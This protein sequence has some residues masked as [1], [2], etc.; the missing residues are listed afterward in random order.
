MIGHGKLDPAY[1]LGKDPDLVVSCRSYPFALGLTTD[2]RT[3]DP[4]LS[5]LASSA[6]QS[7][8]RGA[9]INEAFTLGKTAIYTHAGSKEIA[10]RDW[11][12]VVVTP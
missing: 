6:F 1:T 10:R 11:Q 3:H 8:Y 9:P 12:G 2:T 4:V 7:K 5:F